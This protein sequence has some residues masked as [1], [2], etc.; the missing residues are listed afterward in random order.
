[1]D[2]VSDKELKKVIA[3]FLE[4]GHAENIVAMFRQ[5]PAYLKWSGELLNDERFN[6]RL[7]ISVVFE[8]L[9]DDGNPEL[10]L[11]IPSLATALTSDWDLLRGEA[12]SVLS[13]IGTNTAR[14][15]IVKMKKDPSP[16]IRELVTVILDEWATIPD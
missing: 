11:A 5:E 10:Y 14:N 6:V 12:I 16:Q 3:D 13:I 8:E 15:H 9:K 7:G 2:Q 1:M 4:M